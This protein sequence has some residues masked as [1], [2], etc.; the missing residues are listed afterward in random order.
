MYY[1]L[2][3]EAHDEKDARIYGQPEIITG[4]NIDLGFGIKHQGSIPLIKIIMKENEQGRMT[5]NLIAAGTT[6]LVANS[7]M[8]KMFLATGVDNIQYFDA[9][10]EN[11]VTG[12]VSNDYKIV[13]IVG[14]VNCIDYENSRLEY[15][16]DGGVMFIDE[17][18]LDESKIKDLIMFRLYDFL[19]LIVVHKKVKDMFEQNSISGVKFYLPGEFQ[20]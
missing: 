14:V 11:S 15:Y 20:L 7:K 4:L 8:R 16:P 6:G 10:V 2:V 5:D 13:N 17:L 19:P 12:E 9:V 3:T 1:L 18:V